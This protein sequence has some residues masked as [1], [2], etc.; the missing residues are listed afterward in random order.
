MRFTFE[1]FGNPMKM[2]GGMHPQKNLSDKQQNERYGQHVAQHA[3]EVGGDPRKTKTSTDQDGAAQ[4][5]ERNHGTEE[6]I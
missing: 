2:L 6:Y 1:P 5:D 3:Y 4:F